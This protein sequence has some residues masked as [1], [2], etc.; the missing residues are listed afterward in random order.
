MEVNES[1]GTKTLVLTAELAPLST[2][3]D[4]VIQVGK[5]RVTLDT[6]VNALLT[7]LTL[8]IAVNF[9]QRDVRWGRKL[10]S[11]VNSAKHPS[12]SMT[13]NCAA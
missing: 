13:W 9:R 3:I 11:N 4:G 12:F 5:P 1:E 10:T 2:N 6:V 7:A 8:I